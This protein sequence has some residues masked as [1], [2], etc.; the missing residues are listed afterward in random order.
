MRLIAAIPLVTTPI[1]A[2]SMSGMAIAGHPGTAIAGWASTMVDGARAVW[3]S[4]TEIATRWATAPDTVTVMPESNLVHHLWRLQVPKLLRAEDACR[5]WGD[6][7]WHAHAHDLYARSAT[8][9]ARQRVQTLCRDL[10]H[11]L[12]AIADLVTATEWDAYRCHRAINAR[13]MHIDIDTARWLQD[14]I[15]NRERTR[16]S[17]IGAALG[18]PGMTMTEALRPNGPLDRLLSHFG[19]RLPGRSEDAVLD[20]LESGRCPEQVAPI[21]NDLI[22]HGRITRAKIERICAQVD[23]DGQLRDQFVMWAARTWRFSSQGTQ[24]Q[25]LPRPNEST[26]Y[27]ILAAAIMDSMAAGDSSTIAAALDRTGTATP[28]GK[29]DDALPAILRMC[30]AAAPGHDLIIMD[31][32]AIEP[33]IRAWLSDD[34]AHLAAWAS[35]RD[36]Y[37]ELISGIVGRTITKS[38]D[39]E[40]RRVGKI[41]DIGCGYHMGADAFADLCASND[42]NLFALGLT[43]RGIVRQYREEYQALSNPTHGLW[44]RLEH[45]ALQAI[46]TRASVQVGRIQFAW[47]PG[48]HLDMVLPSGGR[49]RWWH[50]TMQMRPPPWAEPG[51]RTQDQPAVIV[52]PSFGATPDQVMYGGRILENACQAIGRDLLVH[53][54]ITLDRLNIP[55]I[56]HCHDELVVEVPTA[57]TPSALGLVQT[58][59]E[60]APDWARGL[61]LRVEVFDSPIWSKAPV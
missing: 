51:D 6:V 40:L 10:Q 16:A 34:V 14:T 23:P 57:E 3:M 54:M 9:P 15:R 35:K 19:I 30:F 21:L 42:V 29:I 24:V 50:A 25:N 45:G 7:T 53:S 26:D 48:G 12:D 28:S 13:G 41:A 32:N 1:R 18:R 33:R 39:P 55:V 37:A 52:A 49:R 59:T 38:S 56:A 4:S 8:A 60:T 47:M 17:N 11:H 46:M 36:L 31:W 58:T 61:P 2:G 27:R 43:P 44:A 5:I 22:G 20:L